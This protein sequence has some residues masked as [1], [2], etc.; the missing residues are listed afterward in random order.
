M[1]EPK[2][3]KQISKPLLTRR[4][5]SQWAGLSA[6]GVL[7]EGPLVFSKDSSPKPNLL[8]IF[9]DQLGFNHCGY[10]GNSRAQTPH[11]DQLAQQGVNF[12][13]AVSTMPVCCAHRASLMTGKYPT[14]TGMVINELRMNPNHRCLG[15]I[16]TENDYET[17]YIGKWH[18]WASDEDPPVPVKT[19]HK[20]PINSFTPRGK[21]RLGFGSYWAAY[22]YHHEYYNTYYHTETPQKIFYGDGIY[23][24][25]G[26]T[27]LMITWLKEAAK[28]E[29]P[30][31]AVLSYGP[32]MHHGP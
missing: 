7:L 32:P 17:C 13:N 10:S 28:K 5:F 2:Q 27:E 31:V 19:D 9:A 1:K 11:I 21:Y 18:L 15:H 4:E 16:V 24:P 22:N 3:E 12:S 29:K 6:A 20:D 30:F 25:D 23:E 14:T 26:Q 8:Y